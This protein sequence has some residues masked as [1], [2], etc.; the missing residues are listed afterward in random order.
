[1]GLRNA[2][3]K[4]Y[5]VEDGAELQTLSGGTYGLTVSPDRSLLAGID[6]EPNGLAATQVI[7]RRT[8]DF[9]T[10]FT[11]TPPKQPTA[12]GFVGGN[13]A[14][15]V[16]GDGII[17]LWNMTDG[18]LIT[19]VPAPDAGLRTGLVSAGNLVALTMWDGVKVYSALSEF[20]AGLTDVGLKLNWRG[21]AGPYTIESAP[22]ITGPW[23][24]DVTTDGSSIER[25][26]EL[27]QRY[28][29]LRSN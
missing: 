18:K 22:S 13:G 5:S 23:T 3:L 6:V 9:S 29:R 26:A 7:V 2:R 12:I 15:A 11:I 14:L 28:Y 27:P 19:E 16:Y 10:A 4:I 21:I 17:T 8:S 25:S 24:A 20:R 1:V